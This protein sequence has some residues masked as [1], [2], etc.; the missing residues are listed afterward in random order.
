MT[1][2]NSDSNSDR[3]ALEQAF[4]ELREEYAALEGDYKEA[5]E[6]LGLFAVLAAIAFTAYVPTAVE[7]R[8]AAAV[9]IFGV[10]GLLIWRALF[11]HSRME[12]LREERRRRRQQG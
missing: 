8:I 5:R 7:S 6:N 11:T 12:R 4:L 9:W 2:N 10:W 3:K 1:D